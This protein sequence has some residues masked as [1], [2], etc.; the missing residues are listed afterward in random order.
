MKKQEIFRNIAIICG[1]IVLL[2]ISLFGYAYFLKTQL[3]GE[4][5][6][7][8]EEISEQ[9]AKTIHAEVYSHFTL[10]EEIATELTRN[11]YFDLEESI[12]LLNERKGNY[13]FKRIGI[14]MLGDECVLSDGTRL[15]TMSGDDDSWREKNGTWVSNLLTD[16]I[17]NKKVIAYST[18]VKVNGKVKAILFATM[19]TAKFRSL[20]EVHSFNSEGYSYVVRVNGD[21]VVDS[22]HPTS[23]DLSNIFTN[24]MNANPKNKKAVNIMKSDF[25]E[26]KEGI[27]IFNN[28]VDKYLYYTPLEINDWYLAHIVPENV[29][30]ER[31]S[32]IM[33]R[34][35]LICAVLI[36][37]FIS[38]TMYWFWYSKRNKE[39]IN[40]M[41][42][43]D[44]VT[45]GLSQ[46]K[47]LY[48]A[49]E[50]LK[51][52][53]RPA[54]ILS[55][56][57][58]N[59][60]LVNEIFGRDTG[61]VLLWH[62]HASMEK[63]LSKKNLYAR[64][65][66]DRFYALVYYNTVEQ[67]TEY[68]KLLC[69]YI[70]K[71]APERFETF[72]LK[73]SVGIYL[74]KDRNISVQ[75]MMNAASF[76]RG[77]IKKNGR[78]QL[79]AFYTDEHRN[80]LLHDKQL[81]DELEVALKNDEFVPYFQPQYRA[82][83]KTICGAEALMRWQKSDGTIVPPG[84]FIPLAEKNG[85]ISQLDENMF[86]M[87]CRCQRELLD[88]GIKP[89]PVS[90]NMSRQLLYDNQFIEKYMGTM[91]RFSLPVDLIELEITETAL[92]EN[93]DK[94]VHI[95]QK[96]HD[97]GFRILMDDFGTGYSSLM[98][99]KSIPIDI[100]KLDKTFID[101][102]DSEEGVNIIKCVTDLAKSLKIS[103]I[104]EG[105][106][107]EEQYKLLCGFKCD[108][109]QGYYF[110]KPV[111]FEVYKNMLENTQKKNIVQ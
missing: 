83:D 59:F 1:I 57:L 21:G 109:I 104:A 29:I 24:M 97:N 62:V 106:E 37:T 4:M 32:N 51:Q 68:V 76:A 41:L 72:I 5:K 95:I 90:V 34:T 65:M 52:N 36:L 39:E 66:A 22:S 100:M 94:F 20:V 73:P 102:Y 45:G 33:Q 81:A 85:F 86:Y 88:S 26:K 84:E 91:Q 61:D 55:L 64:G 28:K 69:E 47:F 2:A 43:T 7:T 23:F 101:E 17:D 10:M 82:E 78:E 30:S 42:Y 107:I 40:K 71:K 27:V 46:A 13:P 77:A 56:D 60:K 67:L 38:A 6:L 63:I 79:Y 31:M 58:N 75:E 108:I 25:E 53:D 12:S 93:Q 16:T 15:F 89:P 50:S 105:V 99:L 3:E 35:Y 14:N 44:P 74:V 11:G 103:V 111:S 110:S 9:S 92:F 48:D 49:A 87:V 96:L 18:P 98:M 54:A 8:L 19:D 80:K 70:V